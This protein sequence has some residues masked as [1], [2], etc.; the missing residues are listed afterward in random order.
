MLFLGRG[1]DIDEFVHRASDED[2]LQ[3]GFLDLLPFLLGPRR[4]EVLDAAEGVDPLPFATLGLVDRGEGENVL[5]LFGFTEHRVDL[6]DQVLDVVLAFALAFPYHHSE[7]FELVNQ[8]I[9]HSFLLRLEQL[10]DLAF[11][12]LVQLRQV[13]VEVLGL[14][15]D[16][17]VDELLSDVASCNLAGDALT[18]KEEG[19]LEKGCRVAAED[20]VRGSEVLLEQVFVGR[21]VANDTLGCI[22]VGGEVGHEGV[23][24]P[25]NR[26]GATH[27]DVERE[28]L[29]LGGFHEKVHGVRV[30][31]CETVDRLAIVTHEDHPAIPRVQHLH[32][33]G[34]TSTVGVLGF[35][36][37]DPL[38]LEEERLVDERR[39]DH[40]VV[41][42]DLPADREGTVV[43]LDRGLDDF[44]EGEAGSTAILVEDI[45]EFGFEIVVDPEVVPS[46][47]V[48]DCGVAAAGDAET[49]ALGE[50]NE[51]PDDVLARLPDRGIRGLVEGL[52][53]RA[54]LVLVEL[55][56]GSNSP[57]CTATEAVGGVDLE[58]S[59]GE[60]EVLGLVAE[61]V[62]DVAVERG[63]V[64]IAQVVLDDGLDHFE[65]GESLAATGAGEESERAL[66]FEDPLLDS[67]LLGEEGDRLGDRGLVHFQPF[68][69]FR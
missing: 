12:V 55:G 20:D 34:S 14:P 51:L 42:D 48:R 64:D 50:A 10:L 9:H 11:L 2:V 59:P 8:P 61:L 3:V 18:E 43:D 25:Y 37:E 36:D 30:G 29:R 49:R 35:V 65:E 33:E 24:A 66:G 21:E 27:R 15:A 5:A 67:R 52:D 38:L 13:L 45:G 58:E 40:V 26:L 44:V 63:H 6:G 39:E 4:G 53:D 68:Q 19:G 60:V 7:A 41:V 28:G 1:G 62:S 17:Q 47:D 31:T 56:V 22:L 23:G 54:D 46:V 16:C 32:R 57:P 69:L